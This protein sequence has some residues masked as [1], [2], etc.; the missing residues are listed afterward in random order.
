MNAQKK[1]LQ[2]FALVAILFSFFSCNGTCNGPLEEKKAKQLISQKF[3]FPSTVTEELPYGEVKYST[4]AGPPNLFA[5]KYLAEQKL[6]TFNYI[7]RGEDLLPY[8]LYYLD[9]T[10]EGQKYITVDTSDNEGKRFY[11]VKVADKV[12]VGGT[13]IFQ[14]SGVTAEVDYTW[15]YDNIT[16]FGKAFSLRNR[17]IS[18]LDLISD[19]PVYDDG[20]IFSKKVKI[21]KYNTGWQIQQ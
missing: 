8:D 15:K 21:F 17:Q 7:R 20:Q 18:I 2:L 10:P 1:L 19:R 5:E 4:F 3:N 6:I 11:L 12:L 13:R 16:P 14:P 9:L